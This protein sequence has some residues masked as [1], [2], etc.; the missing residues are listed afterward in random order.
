MQI[1]ISQVSITLNTQIKTTIKE[2]PEPEG[3]GRQ[4]Q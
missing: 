2:T 4:E 1:N 3:C